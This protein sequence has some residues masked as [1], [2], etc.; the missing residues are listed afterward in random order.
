MITSP[1]TIIGI[2]EIARASIQDTYVTQT[3]YSSITPEFIPGCVVLAQFVACIF[4]VICG[5]FVC[6]F[7]V[8]MFPHYLG[9]PYLKSYFSC[10]QVSQTKFG[11]F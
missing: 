6:L 1:T 9:F 4:C 8:L 2:F 7:V 11:D 10:Y 5:V 3:A